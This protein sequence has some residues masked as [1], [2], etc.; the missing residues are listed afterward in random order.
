MF[1]PFF[2]LVALAIKLDSPGPVLF[3]QLRAGLDGRPF[4]MYKLRTMVADAEA[5]L[6]DLV[7]LDALRGP[8]FKLRDDP[9]VTRVGR[10]LRR[11]SLD[12]LP[13]LG[14]CCAAR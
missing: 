6:G 12:E 9:R 13:Q 1:A 10:L 5:Q 8:V 4:R 3:S 14:T 2:P 7:D 11:L